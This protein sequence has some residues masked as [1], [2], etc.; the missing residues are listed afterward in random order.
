MVPAPVVSTRSARSCSVS[1]VGG[2]GIFGLDTLTGG[3]L[4]VGRAGGIVGGGCG[5]RC[6]HGSGRGLIVIGQVGFM[7]DDGDYVYVL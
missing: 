1:F 3:E 2:F 4:V 6:G 7:N 5:G